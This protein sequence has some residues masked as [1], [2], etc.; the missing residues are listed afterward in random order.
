[1]DGGRSSARSPCRP[2]GSA[3]NGVAV[4]SDSRRS[5]NALDLLPPLT[6]D[7]MSL[8]LL[9]GAPLGFGVCYVQCVQLDGCAR[10][11]LDSG[12][13]W[14]SYRV[15]GTIGY[16]AGLSVVLVFGARA[17]LSTMT[18]AVCAI[19][20]PLAFLSAVKLSALVFGYERIVFYEK[21]L[22][23][24]AA[25]AL[26]LWLVGGE[27]EAGLDLTTL[28][29]GA[30]LAFGRLGCLMVGC[31]F[32]RPASFGVRYTL[33]HADAGFPFRLVGRRLFPIQLLDAGAS[34]LAVAA[35]LRFAER[36][37]AAALIYL[38]IYGVARF[39]LEFWR[40]DGNRPSWLGVTEAQWTAFSIALAV[41]AIA[42]SPLTLAIA[43]AFTVACAVLI[44]ARRLLL[45]QRYWLTFPAHVDE[46]HAM[47]ERL[48]RASHGTG[49]VSSLGLHLSRH[50]LPGDPSMRE[51]LLLSLG[52]KALKSGSVRAL[53]RALGFDA[54]QV[55][56]G[57]V[58]GLVHLLVPTGPELRADLH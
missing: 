29:I 17:G 7:N 10:L 9:R 49:L 40:G 38:S 30:F 14:G 3:L 23:A 20:P 37:G 27:L 19:V 44:V 58:R 5:P 55:V 16:F 56:P 33:S 45:F 53:G 31:C 39:V 54:A 26:A 2:G 46:L 51:D 50:A 4:V 15:L 13:R 42:R 25:T 36:P 41:A 52:K 18:L 35:A 34:A 22:A 43:S 32:G 6:R 47:L 11:H 21:T 28:G 48:R 12:K 24:L 8:N 57:K 1:V